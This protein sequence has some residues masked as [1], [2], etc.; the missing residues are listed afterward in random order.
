[1]KKL[2]YV[3]L[4]I[5][6]SIP[7]IIYSFNSLIVGADS[8]FYINQICGIS[9]FDGRDFLFNLIFPFFQCDFL[10][11]KFYLFLLW[12]GCL[13][14]MAKIGELYD[15]DKGVLAAFVMAGMTLFIFS[16][17]MFENDTLGYFLFFVSLYFLLSYD[18]TGEKFRLVASVIFIILSGLAW[19]GAIY[20]VLI[21]PIFSPILFSLYLIILLNFSNFFFF[22]N[23]DRSISEHTPIVSVIYWGVSMLFLY[24][25]L[26]TD[27]KIVLSFV[28]LAIPALFAVKFF[29]LCIPFISL[30][31]FNALK[32]LKIFNKKTLFTTLFMIAIMA[33]AFWG[34]STFNTFPTLEEYTTIYRA[35]ELDNNVQNVFGVGYVVK[36]LGGTPS[37]FGGH[38][39]NDYNCLGVVI[40]RSFK[41]DCNCPLFSRGGTIL[42][43]NCY[44]E[45]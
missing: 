37:S 41:E 34:L 22:V 7:F 30:I 38:G 39:N 10:F 20:W 40:E 1:M 12:F 14:M 24:G 44:K 13:V 4:F 27:R 17:F 25:F 11:L 2:D 28:I 15:K 6:A 8:Y 31:A 21:Y 42:A 33:G 5:V 9:P 29:V 26:K 45:R 18:K 23:A 36:Y 16:F 3:L 19:K 32:N 35:I 43:K